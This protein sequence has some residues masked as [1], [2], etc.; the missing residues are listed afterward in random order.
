MD[1][2]NREQIFIISYVVTIETG[3]LDFLQPRTRCRILPA[4]GGNLFNA[5]MI[6]S[7]VLRTR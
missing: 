6:Y 3:V 5:Q 2:G 4:S 7:T 1:F